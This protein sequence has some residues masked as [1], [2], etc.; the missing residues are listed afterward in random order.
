MQKIQIYL[1][2]SKNY[3]TFADESGFST[4]SMKRLT[5][6]LFLL[7]PIWCL[8]SYAQTPYDSFAPEI[9][10]PVLDID[11]IKARDAYYAQQ[12]IT[13]DTALY[14]V[15]M[16]DGSVIDTV[17]ITDD[18]RKWLSVDPLT[19]KYPNISPYAYCSWNPVKFVD[20]DGKKVVYNDVTGDC[21]SM[22]DEFCS[23]SAMFEATYNQ[24][25]ESN[26]IYTFQFGKTNNNVDGQFVPSEKGG[27][28][29]LNRDASWG[30]AIPEET[31][32]ALQKDN[33]G[34]YNDTQLNLEFE[35]KVFVIMS[36]LPTRSYYGMDES[37]YTSLLKMDINEFTQPQSIAEYIKQAN[38]YSTYNKDN[39]IGN[40]NY[41]TPTTI[42]PYNL[43]SIIGKL[44]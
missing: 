10:R 25:E 2:I 24:L 42:S 37:Y 33:K 43:I 35:A 41:W 34:K 27:V 23:Q 36:E 39:G 28:I 31:F 12:A 6:I 26:D 14:I 17:L 30:L 32:H 22:V 13:T 29:L 8:F 7:V 19:D 18:L 44:K 11:F 5:N 15:D 16:R 4:Q 3:C 1:R 21:K 20:P 40:K 9:S 38:I